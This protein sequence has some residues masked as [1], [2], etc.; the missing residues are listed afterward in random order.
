M[1]GSD[2]HLAAEIFDLSRRVVVMIAKSDA[3][4]WRDPERLHCRKKPFG[5][6]NSRKCNDGT[7]FQAFRS[8]KFILS[9][10]KVPIHRSKLC[11]AREPYPPSPSPKETEAVLQ[12]FIQLDN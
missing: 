12:I 2:Q 11:L 5:L 3:F 1:I 8:Y 10:A 6:R 4:H 7:A 9:L